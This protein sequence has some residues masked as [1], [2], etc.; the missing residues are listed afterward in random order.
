MTTERKYTDRDVRENTTLRELAEDYLQNYGG[1]FEPLVSAVAMLRR[2]EELPTNIVRVVLNCMRHDQNVA[3]KMPPPAGYQI[4]SPL[5]E[6]I[7]MPKKRRQ[8]NEIEYIDRQCENTEPHHAHSEYIRDHEGKHITTRVEC[9][10]IPWLINRGIVYAKARVHEG[11]WIKARGGRLLHYASGDAYVQWFMPQHEYGW[12]DRPWNQY[13]HLHAT[14]ICKY[15]PYIQDPILLDKESADRFIKSGL[16]G[17]LD[18]CSG[19]LGVLGE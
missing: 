13:P 14:T 4:S 11:L 7:A 15:G 10:G 17:D 1:D 19:C 2:G 12:P 9:K 8:K 6:V 18:F 16:Y 5:A 3:N